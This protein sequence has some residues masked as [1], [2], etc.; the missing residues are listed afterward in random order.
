[1]NRYFS[2]TYKDLGDKGDKLFNVGKNRFYCILIK[3]NKGVANLVNLAT[4]PP[5][6]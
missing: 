1:M 3:N 6:A 4:L 2:M 5:A